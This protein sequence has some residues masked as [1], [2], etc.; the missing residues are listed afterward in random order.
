MDA[1]LAE[2]ESCGTATLQEARGH[3]PSAAPIS[4]SASIHEHGSKELTVIRSRRLA[5][6]AVLLAGLGLGL[7]GCAYGRAGYGPYAYDGGYYDDGYVFY[8][9]FHDRERFRFHHHHFHHLD[10]PHGRF[11]HEAHGVHPAG[12]PSGFGHGGFGGGRR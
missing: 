6:A 4:W 11:I 3:R 12:H 7:S 1:T 10:P 2:Q 9:D 8:G 5:G